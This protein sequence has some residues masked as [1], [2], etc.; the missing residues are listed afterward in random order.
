MSIAT[1]AT[2]I[3]REI[4]REEEEKE[5]DRRETNNHACMQ[6][7]LKV[8]YNPTNC[9]YKMTLRTKFFAHLLARRCTRMRAFCDQSNCFREST[10]SHE[11]RRT[12]VVPSR[13][14]LHLSFENLDPVPTKVQASPHTS[15]SL[16]PPQ[17]I[18][19]G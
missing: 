10:R 12:K 19:P 9:T 13:L 15:S 11:G 14:L 17:R 7:N 16:R 8:R 4:L 5:R 18:I 6:C 3:A 1:V 2:Y